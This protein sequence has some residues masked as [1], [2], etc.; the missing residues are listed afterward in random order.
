MSPDIIKLE[1]YRPYA[2]AAQRY[3]YI[4]R[5]CHQQCFGRQLSLTETQ[6][7]LRDLEQQDRNT[8]RKQQWAERLRFMVR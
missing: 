7:R 3:R 6:W 4:F 5:A 8:E 2:E 1:E